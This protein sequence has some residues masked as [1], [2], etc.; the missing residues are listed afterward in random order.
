MNRLES[1][2]AQRRGFLRKVLTWQREKYMPGPKGLEFELLSDK[3]EGYLMSQTDPQILLS[4]LM[5]ICHQQRRKNI[6]LIKDAAEY[7]IEVHKPQ[8][9]RDGTTPYVVHPLRSAIRLALADQANDVSIAVEVLHDAEEDQKVSREDIIHQFHV[10]HGHSWEDTLTIYDG[11]HLLNKN[12][13]VNG[14]RISREEFYESID[15]ASLAF[16]ERHY[17]ETKGEDRYDNFL[18]DLYNAI[19]AKSQ[20]EL[21]AKRVEDVRSYLAKFSEALGYVLRREK[22]S[23][24]AKRAERADGLGKMILDEYILQNFGTNAFTARQST[25]SVSDDERV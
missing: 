16:P 17:W 23:G 15:K 25:A 2:D 21:Y 9:R 11:I 7:A 10:K 12:R 4:D 22:G 8:Y 5:T 18:N 13:K 6:P 14:V 1:P 19:K 3:G 24:V 20:S